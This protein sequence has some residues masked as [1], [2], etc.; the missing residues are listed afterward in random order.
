MEKAEIVC[1]AVKWPRPY[2]KVQKD[3]ILKFR[4]DPATADDLE[5]LGRNPFSEDGMGEI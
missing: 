5:S 2:W 4:G 1:V 3:G